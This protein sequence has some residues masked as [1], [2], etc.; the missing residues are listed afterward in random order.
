MS[1]EAKKKPTGDGINQLVRGIPVGNMTGKMKVR[2]HY[3]F[4]KQKRINAFA[5]VF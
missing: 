4:V 1:L 5:I 2:S 3:M